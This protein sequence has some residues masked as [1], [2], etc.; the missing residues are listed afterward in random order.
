LKNYLIARLQKEFRKEERDF[1][2]FD[3]QNFKDGQLKDFLIENQLN[4]QEIITLTAALVPHMFPAFFNNTI[5][6]YLPEGGEFPEFGGV[7]GKNHPLF[8]VC[9]FKLILKH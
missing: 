5:S 8:E 9:N 7:K 1:P 6:E 4:Q 3:V 2:I